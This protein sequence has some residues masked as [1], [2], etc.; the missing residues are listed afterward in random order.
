[1]AAFGPEVLRLVL[2]CTDAET[3]PK[4]AWRPRKEGY[5]ADLASADRAVLL[6][7]AAD[8]LHNARAI[9]TDKLRVTKTAHS[10]SA[11]LLSARPQIAAGKAQEY[12][13][14]AGICAFALQGVEDFFD[15]IHG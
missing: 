1:M 2:A 10:C 4:P 15:G 9:D 11:I 7:S 5:I 13:R 14:R 8:K 3:L 6:V 12:R